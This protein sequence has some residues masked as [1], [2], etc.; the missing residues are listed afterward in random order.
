[1]MKPDKQ[2]AQVMERQTWEEE[3][4]QRGHC[5]ELNARKMMN[6]PNGKI[7]LESSIDFSDFREDALS[8]RF[9]AENVPA[10]L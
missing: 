4:H 3:D 8:G 7:I 10:L 9:G 6:P 1:M 2:A 5:R